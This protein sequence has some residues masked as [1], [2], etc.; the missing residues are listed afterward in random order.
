[1]GG[2]QVVT[3]SDEEA[4]R[5]GT[6]KTVLERKAPPTFDVLIEIHSTHAL[7]VHHDVAE[8]VDDFLRGDPPRPEQ[9]VR[10]DGGEVEIHAPEPADTTHGERPP[11]A[12]GRQ[13]GRLRWPGRP[14]EPP[15]GRRSRIL[16]VFPYAVSKPRLERAIRK[17]NVPAFLVA[18]P[19]RADVILTT[20]GHERR[21]PRRLR[22]SGRPVYSL[23]GNTI[24]Q[25]EKFLHSMFDVDGGGGEREAAVQEATSA[26]EE[27]R[28]RGQPVELTPRRAPLRRVQHELAGQHRLPSESRGVEPFRRVV[29]FPGQ[30]V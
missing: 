15:A 8:V 30:P 14:P 9:R 27:V 4:R 6:Q 22:D 19:G 20:K 18:E 11:P 28:E 17:L 21:Q 12:D 3:L 1:V 16:K 29:I 13:P 24:T 26:V 7:A 25:M 2:I 5:R 23:R 10:T